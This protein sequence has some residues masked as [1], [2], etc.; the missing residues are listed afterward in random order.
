MNAI[1]LAAEYQRLHDEGTR[2]A[3][4]LT[5]LA[6]RAA[7]YHHV[8]CDSRRNHVFPLI[9]AHGALWASGHFETGRRLAWWLSWQYGYS[10][11][12]RARQLAAVETFAN[13][14]RDVNRR[15]CADTYASYHFTA[16]YGSR[17]DATGY[18]A[19]PLLEALLRVHAARRSGRELTS[20][21][22]LAVFEAHF[23][24]E[25][26]FVVGPTIERASADLDW[27]LVRWLALRP[28]IRMAYFPA[29][30][31]LRFADFSSRRQ[32]IENG[33]KAFHLAAGVGWNETA[34]ALRDYGLLPAAFFAD[35]RAHFASLKQLVLGI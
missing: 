23:L 13:A 34:A 33:L 11:A 14:L 12:R 3:G 7:V 1:D 4:G 20:Q 24:N 18:V 16:L 27:P 30:H 35:D 29:G 17:P 2:L 22:K 25:Q 32:R 19:P 5:D 8:Y 21:E 31:E 10:P 6:Q 9:A 15:V 28:T 26:E